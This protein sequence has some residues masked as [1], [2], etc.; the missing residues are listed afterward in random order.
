M[1][2]SNEKKIS[3]LRNWLS[4]GQR[5]AQLLIGFIILFALSLFLHFR[6]VRVEILD[7]DTTAKNYIV[8]QV[9]FEFPDEERTVLLK[10]ESMRDIGPIYRI[11]QREIREKRYDF[12]KLLIGDHDWRE[13]LPGVTFE[14]MYDAADDVQNALLDSRFADARTIK[15]MDSIGLSTTDYVSY[16]PADA[17]K[18]NELPE[19]FW[20]SINKTL[21]KTKNFQKSTATYVVDFFKKYYYGMFLAS[22][23]QRDVRQAVEEGIPEKF[24]KIQAGSRIID[25][26][27]TVTPRHVALLQA[28][29]KSLGE[30]R[31]LWEPLTILGSILFATLITLLG[32]F[33][34]YYKENEFFRSV[35]KL[36]LYA[37]IV[38]ITLILAKITEYFLLSEN[39]NL[40]DSAMYPLIIPF[41]AILICALLGSNIAIFTT[42]FLSVILGLTLAVD[43]SRF[44]IVNLVGGFVAILASR[45]LKKR[46]EVFVICSKVWVCIIPIFFVYS[47]AQNTFWNFS[48]ISDLTSTFTFLL[49]TAILVVGLLP[50]LESIFH[51]M[52]D[53]TLMEYMDPSNELL[54]RLSIEAPGTYQHCLVV[55]SLAESAAQAIGANGLFCRVS[56]LYHD[57]GK[58]FNPHYFTE[59][60]MG[61][62]NIHQ[63]LTPIESAQ[64]I[65]AHVV[66]GEMLARKHGLPK[67]FIDVIREH[68]GTT[69]VYYFYRKQ[70]QQMDEDESKVDKS[71]FQYPGPKPKSRE[72]AIIMIADTIEAASRSLEE[73]SEEAIMKLVNRLL[74]DKMEDGQFQ[75][76]KLTF[77]EFETVKTVIVKTLAV[78]RHLRV[79]YPEKKSQGN[80]STPPL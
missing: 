70:L 36:S 76:C 4:Q 13:D 3:S 16:V 34:F 17:T 1:A 8:A 10:Q 51:I 53:I 37:I 56:T 38:I 57:I 31:M 74:K 5:G 20:S 44:L 28:M 42:C 58:L 15:K 2:H 25:K 60:Q 40:M 80:G 73:V 47:F 21:V 49:I 39:N 45:Q 24:T 64:V 12:E 11:S 22:E 50:I 63:L 23:D 59:N 78:T 18:T 19:A 55:G 71:Q 35:K 26:G 52:T 6:E 33:Y 66:E 79:K 29:K 30:K 9:D 14:E 61:G 65:I 62:F 48:L 46:K 77:E 75:E 41:T 7:V 54:R 68:H 27:E 32:G 43:H 67:T 72:S 69:L